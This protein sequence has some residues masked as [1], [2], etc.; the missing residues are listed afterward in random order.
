MILQDELAALKREREDCLTTLRLRERQLQ[1]QSKANDENQQ[2]LSEKETLLDSFRQKLNQLENIH[3]QCGAH[4]QE[5]SNLIQNLQSLQDQTQSVIK[6]QE[7]KSKSDVLDLKEQLD[8]ATRLRQTLEEELE[9]SKQQG[10]ETWTTL[11]VD[12]DTMKSEQET[13]IET[14]QQRNRRI[15]SLEKA[16][17]SYERKKNGKSLG[18]DVESK[19]LDDKIFELKKVLEF[20]DNELDSLRA[21]HSNRL[22]RYKNLQHEHKIVLKQLQTFENSSFN[23]DDFARNH[24]DEEDRPRASPRTLQK[25]DSDSVWNELQY[26]KKEY[27]K[28]RKERDDVMEEIDMLRV[29]HSNDVATIHELRMCLEDEKRELVRQLKEDNAREL[30]E[31][32]SEKERLAKKNDDLSCQMEDVKNTCRIKEDENS[33]LLKN[34]SEKE[35]MADRLAGEVLKYKREVKTVKD[36]R[37]KRKICESKYVQVERE[38][39]LG[40]R[41]KMICCDAQVQTDT[42]LEEH[43]LKSTGDL[44]LRVNHKHERQ[45]NA[46]RDAQTSPIKTLQ[47]LSTFNDPSTSSTQSKMFSE[48]SALHPEKTDNV[49]NFGKVLSESFIQPSVETPSRRTRLTYKRSTHRKGKI[50]RQRVLSLIQQVAVLKSAKESL[51]QALS[52]QSS[53][54]EKLQNDYSQ[55]QSRLKMSKQ[56]MERLTKELEE[57]QKRNKELLKRSGANKVPSYPT[58]KHLEDRLKLSANECSRLS[59]ELKA[60]RKTNEELQERLKAFQ[61]KSSRHEQVLSQKKIFVDEMR[62]RLKATLDNLESTRENLRDNEEKIRLLTDKE[63]QRKKQM[64]SLRQRLEITTNEKQRIKE[65]FGKS[66]DEI[67]KKS[68][69]LVQ[70]QQLRHEAE[71]AVKEMEDAAKMQLHNLANH[72]QATLSG[73]E[74]RLNKSTRRIQEF[75]K[76]VRALMKRILDEMTAKKARQNEQRIRKFEEEKK[77]ASMVQA[78]EL[79]SSILDMSR[80]DIDELLDFDISEEGDSIE[81][82]ECRKKVDEMLSKEDSFAIPLLDIF[83][84]TI[85][86]VGL[87]GDDEIETRT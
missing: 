48:N 53:T 63:Q 9:Q 62:S 2:L 45:D 61:E 57:S 39:L 44:I 1:Q 46:K 18:V 33:A 78:C 15:S 4:A 3:G 10:S 40:K 76:F 68:K 50:I 22:Q 82:T 69:L 36:E 13:L 6:A 43:F 27:E 28:L 21:A 81:A 66:Q 54:K 30:K 7:E 25:E 83:L 84:K 73:I 71:M 55:C 86:S 52:E 80:A 17:A 35:K 59:I 26:F 49:D 47:K 70:A 14:L 8:E 23:S 29:E 51:A 77:S 41:K 20:K 16:L 42:I 38:D 72:S 87:L 32:S 64:E 58:E 12:F 5:Q 74:E 31:M 56:T 67:K 19:V 60:A 37:K 65:S 34:L 24:I 75:Q 85:A 11:K 79:A